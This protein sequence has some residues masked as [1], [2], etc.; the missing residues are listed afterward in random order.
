[1]CCS[2]TSLF[3]CRRPSADSSLV[4]H[5]AIVG[6]LDALFVLIW[7]LSTWGGY[8]WPEWPIVVGAVPIA[9]HAWVER[10]HDRPELRRRRALAIHAGVYAALSVF[11]V[12]VWALT[13]PRLVL[14]RVGVARPWHP[15]RGARR[16][17]L[18]PG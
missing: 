3:P 9:I 6:A 4:V 16:N 8:F 10:V 5:V 15:A 12:L 13:E 14:A 7:S 17:R 18:H 11:F 1:M 2:V